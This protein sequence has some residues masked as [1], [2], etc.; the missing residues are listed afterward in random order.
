MPRQNNADQA[1]RFEI[2]G[3]EYELVCPT[4][5]EELA[6]ALHIKD[7][8]QQGC[9]NY[10]PDSNHP[11]YHLLRKQQQFIDEFLSGLGDFDNTLMTRNIVYL[12][13]KHGIRI[14]DLEKILGISTG[15]ISRTAKGSSGKRMSIDNIWRIARLFGIEL[16]ALLETDLQIPNQNTELLTRFLDK[17]RKQTEDNEI[18]WKNCGGAVTRL[19]RWLL[20]LP[21]FRYDQRR[22]KVAYYVDHLNRNA[23]FFLTGDVYVTNDVYPN[24]ELIMVPYSL[25]G[26]DDVDHIDFYFCD[27]RSVAPNS[28]PQL[29]KAFFTLDD[30]FGTLDTYAKVL[31]ERVIAQEMDATLTPDVRKLIAD[32]LI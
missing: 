22:E 2:F 32:Y 18:I 21:Q 8:L 12:T 19:E 20:V 11:Y 23:R 26:R 29:T 24:R 27:R 15:Y 1:A 31:M 6:L 25:E 4:N 3:D 17:L 9:N 16:R 5:P 10:E 14:G 7:L 13:K 28:E 30:R